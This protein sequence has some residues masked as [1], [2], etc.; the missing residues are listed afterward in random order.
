MG[1][2]NSTRRCSSRKRKVE[3]E[4]EQADDD[5]GEVDEPGVERVAGHR[6][7]LSEPVTDA[8]RLGDQHHHPRAEQIE[9]KHDEQARQDRRQN[10]AGIDL[11]LARA[12]RA[13]DVDVVAI[14][15][16][17]LRDG[18]ERHREEQRDEHHE[19]RRPVA[20]AEQEDRH[21]QPR[22]GRDGSEQRHR[23]QD[24][25]AEQA[26]IA[27]QNAHAEAGDRGNG[28]AGQHPH[29]RRRHRDEHGLER[30]RSG[31]G[32]DA[33]L[34]AFGGVEVLR[35]PGEIAEENVRRRQQPMIGDVD[36]PEEFPQAGEQPDRQQAPAELR[37][38]LPDEGDR[39]AE[40]GRGEPRSVGDL[41]L[42]ADLDAGR[43]HAAHADLYLSLA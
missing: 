7:D 16:I 12:H 35:L 40:Q 42:A 9:T 5:D 28:E 37:P 22:D 43:R 15:R 27:D 39:L 14:D 33:D 6:D 10:H 38:V 25:L 41:P 4:A 24:Q 26:V 3:G 36:I 17:D 1:S 20:D 29:R 13:R 18:G 30:R 2:Q 34:P 11:P 21:R 19:D 23:R 8:G 32:I 31:I